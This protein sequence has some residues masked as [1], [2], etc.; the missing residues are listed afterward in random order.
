MWAWQP[1]PFF[2]SLLLTAHCSLL[3]S[4]SLLLSPPTP[5][6]I[7]SR[8][9]C[10][11]VHITETALAERTNRVRSHRLPDLQLGSRMMVGEE[12]VGALEDSRD[13]TDWMS[14]WSPLSGT[15][16]LAVGV[17]PHTCSPRCSGPIDAPSGWARAQ[18]G[19]LWSSHSGHFPRVPHIPEA[20]SSLKHSEVLQNT[21]NYSVNSG[22]TNTPDTTAEATAEATAGETGPISG[23]RLQLPH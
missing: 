3:Q 16:R 17:P 18:F 23:T 10:L 8:R 5:P 1:G 2:F 15:S 7:F 20:P 4:S 21:S 12:E 14:W 9:T 19:E 6:L 22:Q 13:V 11:G